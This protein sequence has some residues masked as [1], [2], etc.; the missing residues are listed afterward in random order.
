MPRDLMRLLHFM[1][2]GDGSE[3]GEGDDAAAQEAAR[4]KEAQEAERIAQEAAAAA[5]D[6][7]SR[8]EHQKVQRE[9]QN[10]RERLKKAEDASLSDTEKVKKERDE[11]KTAQTELN[12]R[13]RV[14]QVQVLASK[15]GIVDP[16]VAAKLLD[17]DDLGENA[18]D[19]KIES[20]LKALVK[21]KPYLAGNAPGGSD[22]GAGD[23]T[24]S[25][26]DDMNTM[27]R[28]MAGRG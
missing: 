15:A 26:S 28:Q 18:T 19:K 1:P 10:L 27:I 5:D 6:K 14:L 2:E 13:V 4:A 11:L 17:W 22:G 12:E 25:E 23:G 21:E 20:A 8:A 9:A 24:G 3:S 7:V 16:D